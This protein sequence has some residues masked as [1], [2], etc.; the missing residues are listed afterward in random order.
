M[1]GKDLKMKEPTD[2]ELNEVYTLLGFPV[3]P[4]VTGPEKKYGRNE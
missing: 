3:P 1:D 2:E 4:P